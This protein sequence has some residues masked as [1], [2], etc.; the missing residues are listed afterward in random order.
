[1]SLGYAALLT[2]TP[3]DIKNVEPVLLP[4]PQCKGSRI[5]RSVE[6]SN[7][8]SPTQNVI[9][10]THTD[11]LMAIKPPVH[12]HNRAVYK[13]PKGRPR[14]L[15]FDR[16]FE[17]AR[18]LHCQNQGVQKTPMS[19]MSA[20]QPEGHYASAKLQISFDFCARFGRNMSEDATNS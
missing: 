8:E 10:I 1:M 13:H 6:T 3:V 15:V 16:S 9:V 11:T 20:Q 18:F 5:A 2:P 19:M 4:V 7:D 14:C 12:I 17:F